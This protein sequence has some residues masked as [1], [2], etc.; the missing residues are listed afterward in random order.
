MGGVVKS[1]ESDFT[2]FTPYAY[3]PAREATVYTLTAAPEEAPGTLYVRLVGELESMITGQKGDLDAVS[4][5]TT[6]GASY[7][8]GSAATAHMEYAL[9]SED[10]PR[11]QL[12]HGL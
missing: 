2:V 10:V 7:Y 9:V 8:S 1:D 3:T 4:S 6:G 12:H 5:A 11:R